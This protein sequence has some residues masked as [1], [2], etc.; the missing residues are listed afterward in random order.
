MFE[1][2]GRHSNVLEMANSCDNDLTAIS[3]GAAE[4]PGYGLLFEEREHL[5]QTIHLSLREFLLDAN[6]SGSYA[7]NVGRGHLILTQSCLQIMLGRTTGPTLAYALRHGHVHLTSVLSEFTVDSIG[8]VRNWFS[9]WLKPRFGA[10]AME[11]D[12]AEPNLEPADAPPVQ[13]PQLEKTEQLAFQLHSGAIIYTARDFLDA[14]K[15]LQ[16]MELLTVSTSDGLT[17]A[18]VQALTDDDLLRA[19]IKKEFHRKR[20]LRMAKQMLHVGD[21]GARTS[22]VDANA[23]MSRCPRELEL[24]P[25]L[26]ELEPEPE[27]EQELEADRN[28]KSPR[29]YKLSLWRA[30]GA[31][32]NWL[33]RQAAH[34]RS[35][36]L[37]PELLS[38]E[39]KLFKWSQDDPQEWIRAFWQ[40]IQH[41][42]WGIGAFW[43]PHYDTNQTIARAMFAANLCANGP[44]HLSE[45]STKLGTHRMCLPMRVGISPTLHQFLGHTGS[46]MS[47]SFSHDG[48]K[49]VSAS[50]DNTVRIW[51]AVTGE[52]EQTLAGNTGSVYSA[53]FS[54][55]GEKVVSADWKTVRIWSAMTGEC[56]Q[57]LAG[58]TGWVY[59]ASF[60]HDGEKVVSASEDNTV[61]IWSAV[62]GEC[63]QTLAGHT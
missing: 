19:G 36:L 44:L 60:S 61:R 26:S 45:A 38:L 63:E 27:L 12:E 33:E 20:F 46:V 25:E 2:I 4:L 39:E 21:I 22:H 35:K 54:H 51:S 58:H 15:L 48:E 6:R 55:D 8:V 10:R 13:P 62:T 16:Y 42:R 30:R 14:A 59:C 57:T 53:S 7:A 5:L 29:C 17:V 23:Q 34:G 31:V 56:E 32:A 47:A 43:A 37:A 24:E 41:L 40:L 52:C 28:V 3:L 9:A 50:E 11:C 49:V 18:G 1:Y